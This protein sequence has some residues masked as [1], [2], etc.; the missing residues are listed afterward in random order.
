M[1]ADIAD[2]NGLEVFDVPGDGNC[3]LH[4]VADQL[5][6]RSMNDDDWESV[7]RFTNT[8]VLRQE[9]AKFLRT[10]ADLAS[11]DFIVR[12]EYKDKET[13]ISKQSED[14]QWCDEPMIRSVSHSVRRKI[15]IFHDNGHVTTITPNLPMCDNCPTIT[16]GQ[17]AENHYV[18]LRPKVA[19]APNPFDR[20]I[21]WVSGLNSDSDRSTKT[22]EEMNSV[23]VTGSA[24]DAAGMLGCCRPTSSLDKRQQCVHKFHP[25]S[26]F[27]FPKRQFGNKGEQRSFRPEWCQQFEWL[28]YDVNEDA[29]FCHVCMSA[30]YEKKFLASTKR[31]KCFISKG[32]TYWKEG[33]CAFKKHAASACHRESVIAIQKLPKECSDVAEI[34]SAEHQREKTINRKMFLIILQ[35]LR[36]LARQGLALR[37]HND[38]DNSNFTQLLHLKA[39]DNP[40]LVTWINKKTNKY[41][42]PDVQNEC[43]QLMALH[44]LRQINCN[45]GKH[46][47][48]TIMADECTDVSN[49]EQFTICI[50]W[51]DDDINDYEDFI[52]LYNVGTIDANCLFATIRDVLIRMNLS[53]SSCRGQCYDGASNM[54]GSKNGVATQIQ[55]E[56]HRAVYTHCYGHAL[57]LAVGAALK[58]SKVC[59]DSL[60]VAFEI[61]RLVR[62]SPKRQSAFER[63]QLDD[64][65]DNELSNTGIRSFCATR[66][67]VRGAAV[68]SILDN[69]GTLMKL[70]NECLETRLEADVKCRIIGVKT[71]MCEYKVF[72]GLQLS[73][74]ILGITDNLSKALQQQSMSAAEGQEIADISVQTLKA[75]RTDTE[76]IVFYHFV[77]KLRQNN[78]VAEAVLPRGKRAPRRFEV[79]I[80]EGSS[81]NSIEDHYRRQY[82][83]ALDCA[84]NGITDR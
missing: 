75:M 69:Y 65:F 61:C 52:G 6:I 37:G 1:L 14:G 51:T 31:D 39:L 77:N 17:I 24:K 72:F 59:C 84:I 26:S 64:S 20:E 21:L 67:T 76:F 70:W 7:S 81:C 11:G 79:G 29:V 46:G 58:Q 78:N 32:F 48:F 5:R 74:K 15:K 8:S 42:S 56:E 16:V 66:W 38:D 22:D 34:L 40:E 35:C 60:D 45:I 43:L 9:A 3:F 30:E 83:E 50:R 57:N 4:S 19:V 41:T 18:S 27:T 73:A 49:K 63:I 54:A 53:L 71:Q 10:S 36:Y 12:A 23:N 13:Y 62:F 47:F 28:H 82:F 33:I 68:V 80:S 44:V 55:A 25:P 2:R